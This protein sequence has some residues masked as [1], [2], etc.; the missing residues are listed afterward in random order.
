MK[1][2]RILLFENSYGCVKEHFFVRLHEYF[3]CLLGLL[4]RWGAKKSVEKVGGQK[5]RPLF[6]KPKKWGISKKKWARG[7]HINK[8]TFFAIN[9]YAH[10]Q[11]MNMGEK[12]PTS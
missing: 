11:N 5:K 12:Y 2:S 10:T 9:V 6:Q 7:G 3:W 8:N 4:G 1:R